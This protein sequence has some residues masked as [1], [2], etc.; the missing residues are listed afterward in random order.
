MSRRRIGQEVLGLTPDQ[1]GGRSSLDQV[2]GLIDRVPV[3]SCLD[4]IFMRQPQV[5][6]LGLPW[7]CSRRY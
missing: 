4:G 7:R 6:Q 2:A 3:E 5:S 1:R